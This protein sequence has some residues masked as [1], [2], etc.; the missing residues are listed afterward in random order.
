MS[1]TK[2]LLFTACS[3]SSTLHASISLPAYA[4][5]TIAITGGPTWTK[6]TQNQPIELV[7]GGYN[8]YIA[9][10]PG[11]TLFQGELFVGW[12]RALSQVKAYLQYGFTYFI[13]SSAEIDGVIQQFGLPQFT[14]ESYQYKISHSHVGIKGKLIEAK[15]EKMPQFY[16]G[17]SIGV[18]FNDAHG[19]TNTPLIS[20]V[21]PSPN[22]TPHT[23]T[24]F[25]YTVL[26]GMQK[27]FRK[28]WAFG[29]EYLFADWGNSYLG[30]APGQTTNQGPKLSQLY[31]NGLQFSVTY[32]Q[33][34]QTQNAS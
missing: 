14:N 10:S 11:D 28:D 33:D 32:H 8:T 12:Q 17:G 9:Y 5:D 3:I 2:W 22:F 7:P 21:L 27:V 19:Y 26:A 20:T 24:S 34:C 13:T 31:T 15:K 29:I 25:T 1:Y 16:V 4:P 30:R 18:G 6:N 23:E